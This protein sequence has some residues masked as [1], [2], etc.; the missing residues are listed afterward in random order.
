MLI[1]KMKKMP[2]PAWRVTWIVEALLYIGQICGSNGLV[3]GG[4]S[5]SLEPLNIPNVLIS[6]DFS[7][8]FMKNQIL[9][10]IEFR[11]HS[12]DSIQIP[13]RATGQTQ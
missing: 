12:I 11:N 3:S 7:R 2:K 6:L 13:N 4:S 8:F 9:E 5:G 1:K 10:P